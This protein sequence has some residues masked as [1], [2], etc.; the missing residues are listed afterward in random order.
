LLARGAPKGHSSTQCPT[1]WAAHLLKER[2]GN[3][4]IRRAIENLMRDEVGLVQLTNGT[5]KAKK[6]KKTKQNKSMS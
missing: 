1:W 4:K 3:A 5:K 6:T 2:K